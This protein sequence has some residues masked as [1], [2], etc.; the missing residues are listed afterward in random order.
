MFKTYLLDCLAKGTD[1]E[2]DCQAYM[3][4]E[5]LCNGIFNLS[6]GGK[7]KK[8]QAELKQKRC[9]MLRMRKI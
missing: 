3:L 5:E 4:I 7:K 2:A 6:T 9:K 1:L 8:N